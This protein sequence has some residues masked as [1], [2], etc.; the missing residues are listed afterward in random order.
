MVMK[1]INLSE[2]RKEQE[3]ARHEAEFPKHR[4]RK[5]ISVVECLRQRRYVPLDK[6]HKCHYLKHFTIEVNEIVAICN[7]TENNHL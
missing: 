5:V 2:I 6:C 4:R 1:I 7:Y 3:D